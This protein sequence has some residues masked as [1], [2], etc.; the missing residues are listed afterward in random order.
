MKRIILHWT[1]G[2]STAGDLDREHYHFIVEG[3]GRVTP[4]DRRPEDN[5]DI[6]DNI[7]AAHTLN[8][9]TGAIG[10]ALAGM[11]GA[12]EQ[13]FTAGQFP[14]TASQMDA[15]CALV[16]RLCAQYSIPVTRQT[17]LT[18]AEVQPTLGIKQLGK[19]DIARLPWDAS[20]QGAIPVGDWIRSKVVAAA[21][22]AMPGDPLSAWFASAPA[23]AIDWLRNIPSKG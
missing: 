1:A 8:C 22:Q 20:I 9:N 6:S 18:H 15:A 13:P 21:I 23:G 19:W 5:E 16:A 17:V 3:S 2:T 7:Y 12:I 4:G 14:I 10:V 11:F